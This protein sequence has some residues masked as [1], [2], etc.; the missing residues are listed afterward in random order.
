MNSNLPVVANP[1][2][3]EA[4]IQL[5]PRSFLSDLAKTTVIYVVAYGTILGVLLH[6]YV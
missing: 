2:A 5:E 1:V 3:V 6:H 4:G